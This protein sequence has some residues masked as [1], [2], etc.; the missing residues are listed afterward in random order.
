MI[1]DESRRNTHKIVSLNYGRFVPKSI[2]TQYLVDSYPV[3][4]GFVSTFGLILINYAYL[5]QQNTHNLV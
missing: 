3:F 1:R 5:G 2:R 4:G